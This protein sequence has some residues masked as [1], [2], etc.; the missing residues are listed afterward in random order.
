MIREWCDACGRRMVW[1]EVF[2]QGRA[3]R[4]PERCGYDDGPTI[5]DVAGAFWSAI[6]HERAKCEALVLR[7]LVPGDFYEAKDEG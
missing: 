2:A 5:A 1:R 6:A 7:A 3:L 4:C